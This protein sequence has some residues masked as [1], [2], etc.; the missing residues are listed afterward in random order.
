MFGENDD[1]LPEEGPAEGHSSPRVVNRRN[2]RRAGIRRAGCE[3]SSIIEKKTTPNIEKTQ[4]NSRK[5]RKGQ[6]AAAGYG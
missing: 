4:G 1:A 3:K 5:I 2:V 6:L